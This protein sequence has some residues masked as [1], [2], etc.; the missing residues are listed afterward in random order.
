MPEDILDVEENETVNPFEKSPEPA[1]ETR[2]ADT[3]LAKK[4]EIAS[5]VSKGKKVFLEYNGKL[6]L[7]GVARRGNLKPGESVEVSLEEAY[8]FMADSCEQLGWR[9][10][11]KK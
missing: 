7:V 2:T 10:F 5:D 3:W 6:E 9:V 8:S 1:I 4:Q 11:T